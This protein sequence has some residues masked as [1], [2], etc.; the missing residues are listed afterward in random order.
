VRVDRTVR[1]ARAVEILGQ[2]EPVTCATVDDA[3]RVA[4]LRAPRS[5]LCELIV[6]G[7]FHRVLHR[8]SIDGQGDLGEPLSRTNG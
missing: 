1:G 8:E 5:R 7:N 3:R 2:R 6:C 4:Y